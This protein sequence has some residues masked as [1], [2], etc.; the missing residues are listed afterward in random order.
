MYISKNAIDKYKS[1]Y[2]INGFYL[3]ICKDISDAVSQNDFMEI[4]KYLKPLLIK[5]LKT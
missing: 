1:V 2:N 4:H 3:P 5:N